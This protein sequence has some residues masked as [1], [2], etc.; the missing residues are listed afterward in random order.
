MADYRRKEYRGSLLLVQECGPV[1]IVVDTDAKTVTP[2]L[3]KADSAYSVAGGGSFDYLIPK[4]TFN[5]DGVNVFNINAEKLENLTQDT[6]VAFMAVMGIYT[7]AGS[8]L[9]EKAYERMNL[10]A[11]DATIAQIEKQGGVW[12]ISFYD[13][14][15]EGSITMAAGN[16]LQ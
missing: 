10:Y 6:T 9:Y 7:L 8:A 14:G 16:L 3:A 1:D 4:Q 11:E 15:S 5:L 2:S 13:V 12:K